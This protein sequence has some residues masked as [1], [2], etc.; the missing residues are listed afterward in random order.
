MELAKSCCRTPPGATVC[1]PRIWPAKGFLTA[2]L[3]LVGPW[4]LALGRPAPRNLLFPLVEI[5]FPSVGEDDQRVSQGGKSWRR[6]ALIALAII[7]ALCLIFHRPLLLTLGERAIKYFA[8]RERLAIDLRLEGNVFTR[9]VAKQVHMKTT[10]PNLIES[11][12]VEY[13]RADYSLWRLIRQG[14][15]SSLRNVEIRTARVVLN[16]ANDTIKG[17]VKPD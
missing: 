16:P 5:R 14:W 12:D 4:T 13:L 8:G 10:G 11:V 6:R 2:F 7:F 17:P 9:I 15:E 3:L 1:C